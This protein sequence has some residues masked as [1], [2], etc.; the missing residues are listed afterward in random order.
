[1]FWSFGKGLQMREE[2]ETSIAA[3][4]PTVDW[5]V[6]D[7]ALPRR[8]PAAMGSTLGDSQVLK[9][10]TSYV[11]MLDEH[12]AWASPRLRQ[13]VATHVQD[14]VTLAL[15]A[16]RDAAE[17]ADDRDVRAARLRTIKA[18]ILARL[19]ANQS[20]AAVAR[21]HGVSPRYLQRLFEIEGTTFSKFLRDQ[22]LAHARRMLGEIGRA[23][24]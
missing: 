21:R 7:I 19:G 24:V 5:R 14:L 3:L 20:V 10:L 11:D 15:D 9:L 13:A 6:L 18:D 2:T 16:T 1:M 12:H 23:H 17:A 4:M 8:T 22:R